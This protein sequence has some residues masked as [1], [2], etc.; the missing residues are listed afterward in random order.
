MAVYHRIEIN[1]KILMGKPVIKGT[2]IPVEAILRK[3]SQKATEKELLESYP[4]LCPE[5]IQAAVLYA[6]ET[7]AHEE[8]VTIDQASA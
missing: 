6:A 5:D 8:T 2:R 4:A 1:P 7:I 3:L